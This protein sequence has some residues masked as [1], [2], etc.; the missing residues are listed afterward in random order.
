MPKVQTQAEANRLNRTGVH[1]PY[2]AVNGHLMLAPLRFPKR[3]FYLVGDEIQ[4]ESWDAYCAPAC[5]HAEL[6]PLEDW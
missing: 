4:Y 5:K 6:G 1:G 3:G 2:Q